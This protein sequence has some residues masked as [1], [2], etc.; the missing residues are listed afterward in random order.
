MVRYR[1]NVVPGGTF[2]FTVTLRDRRS[3]VLVDHVDLLRDFE[4]RERRDRFM[5]MRS[6]FFRSI[7]TR[8][9]PCRPGIRI[10]PAGGGKSKAHLREALVRKEGNSRVI[11]A[12]NMIS[13]NAGSGSTPFATTA[14]FSVA[15]ITFTTIRPSTDWCNRPWTGSCHHSIAISARARCRRIGEALVLRLREISASRFSGP[16]LRFAP[17]GLRVLHPGYAGLS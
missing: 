6:S 5:S 7:C 13:G 1:R 11:L 2:F 10:S 16:G 14:I 12:A 17:S 15:L 9:G 8:S 3:T 4:Q